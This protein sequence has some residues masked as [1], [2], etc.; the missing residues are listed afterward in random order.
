MMEDLKERVS[1]KIVGR[2]HEITLILAALAA[3]RHILLEGPPGTSKSTILRA[4]AEEMR[5]PF[6][7]ITANSD[8]TATK[9]LG[10]FDP[11]RALA[12]GYR[13]EHFGYGPL[14]QAMRE[15]ALL[16]IEE[17]NRLP[18]ETT[19]VFVTATSEREVV[20]PHLGSIQAAPAFRIIAAMNPYDEVGTSLV[21]RALRDRFCSLKMDYQSKEEEMEIV[22]LRSASRDEFLVDTAVEIAR[23]TR[24]H[25]EVRMGASVRGAIDMVL[26][27]GELLGTAS[28]NTYGVGQTERLVLEAAIMAMRDKVWLL[29]TSNRTAEEIITEIWRTLC[30][31]RASRGEAC[32]GEPSDGVSPKKGAAGLE[33]RK[34]RRAEGRPTLPP[35][36]F[37]PIDQRIRQMLEQGNIEGVLDITQFSPTRVG[38]ALDEYRIALVN[39]VR[40]GHQQAEQLMIITWDQL[41]AETREMLLDMMI[42]L[43][44]KMA[45]AAEARGG[46]TYGQPRP[47]PYRF[48]SDELDLDATVEKIMGK[49]A[50]TYDD[51]LVLERQK[52][53]RAYVIILD[54]SG[55]MK[56]RKMAMAALATASL[57]LSVG[58]EDE[59]A[60]V[61]FSE[62]SALVKPMR[63]PSPFRQVVRDVLSITPDG[64]TDLALA[65]ESGL[66]EL[67]RSQAEKKVGILLSDGWKNMGGDPLAV[68]RWFPR[69]HVLGLPGGDPA[70]CQQIAGVGKGRFMP[71]Q[72]LADMPRAL[73]LC[74]AG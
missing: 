40:S 34:P 62:D 27:A 23:R 46:P 50:L 17:F 26:I 61:L 66:Q 11:A 10:H 24:E 7:F 13:P 48:S 32:P 63:A 9:L 22:R 6:H 16:Y 57:A 20:I 15:G 2:Q 25:E 72:E 33:R 28:G 21:S 65:L 53:R 5:L 4:I 12:E 19:N 39:L 36:L 73:K 3:K 56:G 59:Y 52:R 35:F 74:L 14:T 69:L 47:T 64:C 44:I 37:S 29:E 54:C 43:L 38:E 58:Q 18:D 70:M 8:L 68:A 45:R 49:P 67:R 30:V 51:L 31:E 71:V 1:A 41:D 55:S 60:V 42:R